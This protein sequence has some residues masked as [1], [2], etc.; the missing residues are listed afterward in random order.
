MPAIATDVGGPSTATSAAPVA[1]ITGA[2]RGLGFAL[3]QEL[4]ARGWRVIATCR[5]PDKASDLKAF[6]ASHPS[7]AVEK[8]DVADNAAIDVLSAKLQDQPIDA[9]INNAGVIGEIGAQSPEGF[10]PE[11]FERVL[12][13]NTYA[14]LRLARVLMP[15]I[16]AS[17]Q[18][19]IV[20]VSSGIGSLTKAPEYMQY[21]PAY[22]YAISK[23][24]L[25][26]E[27]RMLATEV[28]PSGVLVGLV[29]PGAV[30]TGMQAQYR[31]A[32]VAARKPITA[33]MLTPEQS[34]RGVVDYIVGLNAEKSG[35]FF[36]HTG[37]ELP[38]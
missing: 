22:Y 33:P 14:P 26:M 31:S 8:L 4:V 29:S 23:A 6:A 25:N 36:S 13:V 15:N 27:M 19:K 10:N 7:V 2:D 30:D 28:K 5:T 11:E 1:L 16:A 21:A 12:R 3:T 18:K 38:W 35:R 17:G 37:A 20:S 24:G 32:S 34:A 9:L